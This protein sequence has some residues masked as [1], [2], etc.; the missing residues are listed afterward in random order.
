MAYKVLGHSRSAH[1]DST[2]KIPVTYHLKDIVGT[3]KQPSG[4]QQDYIVSINRLA[5]SSKSGKGGTGLLIKKGVGFTVDRQPHYVCTVTSGISTPTRSIG[6]TMKNATTE[7]LGQLPLTKSQTAT[8]LS[9]GFLV[10]LLVLLAKG[11]VSTT[12]EALYFLRLL[13][14][15]RRNDHAYYSSKTSKAY[16]LTTQGELL[17][18][19]SLRWHNLG[20]M[21]SGN[22]LTVK[23]TAYPST[24]RECTLSDILEVG[25]HDRYYLSR[26]T[27][28]RIL[29]S[30]KV[31]LV[32]Q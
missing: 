19:S 11:E 7:I 14:L 2:G 16:S 22:C 28:Q 15:H 13:G 30:A 4:N 27:A 31:K 18:Q 12:R 21:Q 8:S 10:R 24:A 20:M 23:I 9:A 6:G 26:A 17:P 25:V 3:L 5:R 29:E 1:K 32:A